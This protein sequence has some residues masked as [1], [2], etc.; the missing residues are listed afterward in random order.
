MLST[1]FVGSWG[2]SQVL[3]I[4]WQALFHLIHLPTPSPVIF[5]FCV[6]ISSGTSKEHFLLT[7][8]C[9]SIC[10]FLVVGWLCHFQKMCTAGPIKIL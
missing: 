3:M 8:C 5:F 4:V 10:F 9:F 2:L 1:C 7:F 6:I